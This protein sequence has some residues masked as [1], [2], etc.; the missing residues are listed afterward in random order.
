MKPPGH[1]YK[2]NA[3]TD[4]AS[5]APDTAN[6][7]EIKPLVTE[8]VN[9]TLSGQTMR[10]TCRKGESAAMIRAQNMVNDKILELRKVAP[11]LSM[12]KIA[13]LASLDFCHELNQKS[14]QL[15]GMS[16]T[17]ELRVKRLMELLA[18]D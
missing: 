9:L 12:E 16:D 15:K 7:D 3:M 10:I 8:Q 6:A 11:G 14:L 13:L 4:F 2:E 5:P 18:G 17:L 1:L